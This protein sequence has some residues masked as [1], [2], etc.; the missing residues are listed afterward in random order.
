M[1]EIMRLAE[2][3]SFDPDTLGSLIDIIGTFI[4][5]GPVTDELMD[6]VMREWPRPSGPMKLWRV[7]VLTKAQAKQLASGLTIPV[8][9][10]LSWTNT[11]AT[12]ERLA[13][14][15]SHVGV[16][17][18]IEMLVPADHICIDVQQFA[19]DLMELERND[20]DEYDFDLYDIV[21]YSDEAEVI[22]MHDQP[23]HLTS[24]NTTVYKPRKVS[25]PKLGDKVYKP[26][27]LSDDAYE[28]TEILGRN[29]DGIWQIKWYEGEDSVR[30][31]APGEWE[32]IE[33]YGRTS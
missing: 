22:T 20:P 4:S 8:H 33:H 27:V 32:V 25:A 7:H 6:I 11:T 10:Y 23:L 3:T 9:R 1:R 12:L 29:K 19:S 24:E 13:A 2:S 15:R 18:I 30:N 31:V 21:S 28:I 17:I 26:H 14:A 5:H 16:P